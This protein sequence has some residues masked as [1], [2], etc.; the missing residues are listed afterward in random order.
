VETYGYRVLKV[1]PES[2]SKKAGLQ[3]FFDFIIGI[4]LEDRIVEFNEEL[5]NFFSIV[6]EKQ[7]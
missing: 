6:A 2:P 7:G 1:A 3:E 5:D 4:K